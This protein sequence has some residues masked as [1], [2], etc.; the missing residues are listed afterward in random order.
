MYE[1]RFGLRCRPF[2][3]TPDSASYYPATGHE[4]ALARLRQAIDACEGIALLLGEPGTGKTLLAQCLL[5]RQG[6]NRPSAYLTNS[7]FADRSALFQAFL[8]EL[9]QPYEGAREQELRLRLTDYLLQHCQTAPGA[10]LMVDEAQHLTPDLLEELRLL[11]NLE[12]GP[13]KALHVILLGQPSLAETLKQPTLAALQQRLQT[14][15][16]LDPLGVE[17]AADYVLHHLRRAGGRAEAI[18]SDEGL[19]LLARQTRGI[20]RL[21]NQ[22]VHQA[23][24]VADAADADHVDAEAALE[25]LAVL[26]IE[27]HEPDEGMAVSLIAGTDADSEDSDAACRLYDAPRRVL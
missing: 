7:H 6:N 19:E 17:E 23:L 2:P 12:A 24:T 9:S 15:V 10:V 21:L 18:I 11:G 14:R 22:A 3:A 20:P 5:E 4:R 26:G 13:R 16:M 25:A 1:T 27:T 8:Y